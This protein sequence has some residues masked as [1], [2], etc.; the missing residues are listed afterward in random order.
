MVLIF[1][2]NSST[3]KNN[4]FAGDSREEGQYNIIDVLCQYLRFSN[5][6]VSFQNKNVSTV[7]CYLAQISISF[8]YNKHPCTG[9]MECR[10]W[11]STRNVAESAWSRRKLKV[12]RP[13][14]YYWRE[15][16]FAIQAITLVYHLVLCRRAS[17]FMS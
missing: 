14:V 15:L 12:A 1:H 11:I 8:H 4:W 16:I 13:V 7:I 10:S 5:F 9:S 6:M 17:S 2:F 3:S